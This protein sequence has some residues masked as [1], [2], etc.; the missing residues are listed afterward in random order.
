MANRAGSLWAVVIIG[1]IGT[2]P[3]YPEHGTTTEH[4]IWVLFLMV[5]ATLV[6]RSLRV[7]LIIGPDRVV[8]R[9]LL[10]TRVIRFEEIEDVAWTPWTR[11]FQFPGEPWWRLQIRY[12]DGKWTRPR[13]VWAPS[14]WSVWRGDAGLDAARDLRH[15]LGGAEAVRSLVLP[16]DLLPSP[17]PPP[18][19]PPKWRR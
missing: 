2:L 6:I 3:F 9:N 1:A 7:D 5:L 16:G 8:V 11:G 17:L 19:D 12:C 14:T 10:T 18:P 13:A 4:V 15:F